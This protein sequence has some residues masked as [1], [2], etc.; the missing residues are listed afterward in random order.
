M[1]TIA[2]QEK[3]V[4]TENV[5]DRECSH[6]PSQVLSHGIRMHISS[7]LDSLLPAAGYRMESNI[8]RKEGIKTIFAGKSLNM[9]HLWPWA[10]YAVKLLMKLGY[11][12]ESISLP[13]LDILF[14]L[15]LGVVCDSLTAFEI[16]VSF[17]AFR[18]H[19][20]AFITV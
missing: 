17:L 7:T 15:G 11:S 3:V 8:H 12:V 13:A 20:K 18:F 19:A 9:M 16:I 14:W 4:F 2:T 1:H 10:D 6:R 5:M